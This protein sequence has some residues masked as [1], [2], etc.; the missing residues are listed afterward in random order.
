VLLSSTR[1]DGKVL[2]RVCVLNH[3]SD[4]SRVDEAADA[5]RRHAG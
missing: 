1:V 4:R 5:L 2:G 3:R